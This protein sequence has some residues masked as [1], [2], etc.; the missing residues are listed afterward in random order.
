MHAFTIGAILDVRSE[1]ISLVDSL[2][3]YTRSITT[4][5]L[6]PLVNYKLLIFTPIYSAMTEDTVIII[7]YIIKFIY[8]NRYILHITDIGIQLCT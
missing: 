7:W 3:N 8:I 1:S 6:I 2:V 4:L 5:D